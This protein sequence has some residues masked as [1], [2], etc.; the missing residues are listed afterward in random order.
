MTE[1]I[2]RFLRQFVIFFLNIQHAE[3]IITKNDK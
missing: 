3:I 1:M 2:D